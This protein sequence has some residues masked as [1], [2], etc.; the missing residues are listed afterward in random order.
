MTGPAAHC[1]R[2]RKGISEP[3]HELRDRAFS[4]LTGRIE[5]LQICWVESKP[6]R[7]CLT[8]RSSV[9]R[10]D[11]SLRT[12]PEMSGRIQTVPLPFYPIRPI[13]VPIGTCPVEP[14]PFRYLFIRSD[15]LRCRLKPKKDILGTHFALENALRD[16]P[17]AKKSPMRPPESPAGRPEPLPIEIPTVLLGFRPP[18]GSQRTS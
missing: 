4:E 15:R 13:S 6:F 1:R 9:F 16:P 2:P 17:E 18:R 3:D 10:I 12:I 7:F 5:R 8:S 14:R 11:G